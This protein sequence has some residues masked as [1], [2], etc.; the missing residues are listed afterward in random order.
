MKFVRKEIR[1]VEYTTIGKLQVSVK[2]F[3][4]LSLKALKSRFKGQ[5]SERIIEGLY[6]D[7]NPKKAKPEK[8][9]SESESNDK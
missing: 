2:D 7:L 9:E 8:E 4:K 3:K 5:F 6:E 1:G